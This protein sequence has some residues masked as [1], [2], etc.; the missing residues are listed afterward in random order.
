MLKVINA[1]V[2]ENQSILLVRKNGVWIL[3]GGKPKG[4]ES[5]LECL[6]R[7][8]SEELSGLQLNNFSFYDEILGISP[9]SKSQVAARL[10][11]AE[12]V[13]NYKKIPYLIP[14]AEIDRAD[15]FMCGESIK[16]PLSNP[17]AKAIHMLKAN[18]FI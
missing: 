12:R 9:H 18:Y 2:I 4:N 6:S 13:G 17:T 16:M 10:Y 5:D 3:P 11:F 1:L 14:S 7:E 8:V 15:F